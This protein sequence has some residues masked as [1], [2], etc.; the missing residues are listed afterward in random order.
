MLVNTLRFLKSFLIPFQF[1]LFLSPISLRASSW[2]RFLYSI[3]RAT[4]PEYTSYLSTS[5]PEDTAFTV[6]PLLSPL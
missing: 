3:F 1:I 5:S 2:T 4:S 6:H